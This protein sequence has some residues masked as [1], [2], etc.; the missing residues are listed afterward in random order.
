LRTLPLSVAT[1]D[2][3][4]TR[5]LATGAVGIDGCEVTYFPLFVEE[6]FVRAFDHE[7]F[8]VVKLS[9]STVCDADIARHVRRT[10]GVGT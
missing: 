1:C 5:A 8:D 10:G 6:M 9:L 3:D 4:R 2:Y 7:E